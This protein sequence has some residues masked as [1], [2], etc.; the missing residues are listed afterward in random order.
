MQP[1]QSSVSF[2]QIFVLMTSTRDRN[3]FNM[4]ELLQ[5]ELFLKLF[6]IT[7]RKLWFQMFIFYWDA[8]PKYNKSKPAK[9]GLL[10]PSINSTELPYTYS[11]VLYAGKTTGESGEH[12]LATTDDIVKCLVSNLRSRVDI[13]SRNIS[14][15][16]YYLSWYCKLVAREKKYRWHN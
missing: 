5:L 10:F 16:R 1:C 2:V 8:F 3:F 14:C 15:D 11:S 6:S 12:Y 4:I 7:V 13:Q 9:Y